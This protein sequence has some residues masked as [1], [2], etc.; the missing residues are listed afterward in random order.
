MSSALHRLLTYL[1]NSIWQVAVIAVASV[2]ATR[3]MTPASWRARHLLVIAAL[4]L[5]IL[6][7]AWSAATS[8][9]KPGESVAVSLLPFAADTSAGHANPAL[10][11]LAPL[12]QRSP[13][14]PHRVENSSSPISRLPALP[15]WRAGVE[16]ASDTEASPPRHDCRT[17]R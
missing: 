11:N 9:P 4:L 6:L 2:I 12:Q 8:T 10:A 1:L 3:L 5:A 7:P 14:D 17:G 16:V 15:R 13:P